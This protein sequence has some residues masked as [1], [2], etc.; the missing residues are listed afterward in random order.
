M[1]QLKH[2]LS[3]RMRNLESVGYINNM[4]TSLIY[5]MSGN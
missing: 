3:E 5:L 1:F 4:D 2:M